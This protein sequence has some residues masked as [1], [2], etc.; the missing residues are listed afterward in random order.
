MAT[1]HHDHAGNGFVYLKGAPEQVLELCNAQ[2]HNAADQTLD[3]SRWQRHVET[4]AAAGQRVLAVAM[5]SA[6]PGQRE[7]SFADAAHGF[8]L[9]GVCGII[10]PPREE[11]KRAVAQCRAAGVRVKMITGDHAATACAIGAQLGIGDG[12]TV[13]TGAQLEA[14]DDAQL[15]HAVLSTD[16]FARASPEHKL[17]LVTAMQANGQVVAMTGDGVN[18]A[19]ALKRAD[20]GVAMGVKGTEA[21]KEAAVMVLAD[22][23]FASIANAVEEGRTVYDNLRKSILFM[24][25]TNVG[26]GTIIVAAILFGFTLPITPLQIL[27]V[28]LITAVTLAM[29][30]AFEPPEAGVMQRPPRDPREPLLSGF[31][32]WRVAFVSVLLLAGAL[33]LFLWETG[34]GASLEVGRTVAVNALMLGQAFYLLSSR[35]SYSSAFNRESL[36]GSRMV[37]LMIAAVLLLQLLF[38]YLPLMQRGFGTAPFDAVAWGR[39]VAFGVTVFVLVEAEKWLMRRVWQQR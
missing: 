8:T 37:L 3:R 32:V 15:R 12:V 31:L 1:L 35:H 7:L 18:D 5:K 6:A 28:N 2:R 36:L 21:A 38:T 20:V 33:G 34:H 23:N 17:R 25:P 24:L 11:A 30:L 14:M 10:D 22:D 19:P 13:L 4:L 27:W 39:I 16:V 26:Q 29:A 9:L